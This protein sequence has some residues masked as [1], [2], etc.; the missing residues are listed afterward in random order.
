MEYLEF[1]E[2]CFHRQNIH[3]NVSLWKT[4]HVNA[5]IFFSNV[6]ISTSNTFHKYYSRVLQ[7]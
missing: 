6:A 4:I 1:Q 5:I 7:L 3:F 2:I